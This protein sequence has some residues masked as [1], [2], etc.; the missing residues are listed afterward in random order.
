MGLLGIASMASQWRGYEY[1]KEGRVTVWEETALQ[2][3]DAVV[4]GSGG[5]R[6]SVHMDLQ[7]PRKSA[8]DCPH[9]KGRRIIC[10]HIAAVY[11][12]VQPDEAKRYYEEVIRAE[13][14]EERRQEK[15]DTLVVNYINGLS[16]QELRQTLYEV[17]YDGADW[18]FER[19]V[20]EH[21]DPS[22]EFL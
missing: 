4:R 6:Y 21:V 11:F 20:R 1:Y 14:E 7:H 8:C 22:G 16:K 9:A 2:V 13:E 5:A 3:Y 12:S 18:V 15:L 10:K 19:F 17:L